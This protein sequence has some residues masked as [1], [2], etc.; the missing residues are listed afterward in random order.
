MYLAVMQV[1]SKFFLM[2]EK[3]AIHFIFY[4]L[5]RIIFKFR[6]LELGPKIASTLSVHLRS[7]TKVYG[8]SLL[9]K[10]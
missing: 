1:I 10:R 9:S 3:E 4:G 2:V 8:K 7:R 5:C 6:V